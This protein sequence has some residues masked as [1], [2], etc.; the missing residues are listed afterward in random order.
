MFNKYNFQMN[1]Y[2][3]KNYL[4]LTQEEKKLVLE[5]RNKNR[6]WMLTQDIITLENHLKWI[7]SLNADT[8]KLYYLVYKDNIP[9][10][11]VSY[12]DIDNESAF[13]GYFLI[14]SSYKNEVLKIEKSIIEI[15]FN[16]LNLE[17]LY[18]I[19]DIN[20][21]VISIHKFFG[22]KEKE[23]KT[24]NNKEYLVMELQKK[25]YH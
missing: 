15:A 23:I 5:H 10:I 22:F 7:D 14:N 4:N 19:N 16:H 11:S 3:F 13:W 18:C 17:T 9:F 20:N 21:H 12:H 24:I 1:E 8:S 25:D 2:I 6:Q